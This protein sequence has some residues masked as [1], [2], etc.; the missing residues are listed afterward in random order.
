M[1]LRRGEVQRFVND[2]RNRRGG[3]FRRW[4]YVWGLRRFR[5]R[6]SNPGGRLNLP[7]QFQ[8]V[9]PQSVSHLQAQI[10][11]LEQLLAKLVLPPDKIDGDEWRGD[12]EQ[13]EHY[14]YELH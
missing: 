4:C 2:W 13:R 3:F 14:E 5:G 11:Q 7:L 10:S 6:S 8:Q 9:A 12:G 1:R